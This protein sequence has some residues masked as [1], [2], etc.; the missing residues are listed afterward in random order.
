MKIQKFIIAFTC[1]VCNVAPCACKI[2]WEKKAPKLRGHDI[3]AQGRQAEVCPKFLTIFLYKQNLN[4]LGPIK[5]DPK[6][7][8]FKAM[9]TT[10]H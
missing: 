5:T 2:Y 6:S 9:K 1:L 3:D 10:E 7:S 8:F 4:V